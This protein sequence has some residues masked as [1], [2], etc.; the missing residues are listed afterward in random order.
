[1]E[2]IWLARPEEPARGTPVAIKDLL[3]T[4]GLVTTY[5]SALFAGHM[6]SSTAMSV[7]DVLR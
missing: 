5:G 7:T 3:D 2:G 1:M 4:A 6:P